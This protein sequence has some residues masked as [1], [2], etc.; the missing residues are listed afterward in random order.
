MEGEDIF[1]VVCVLGMFGATAYHI[2]MQIKSNWQERHREP[3]K[4]TP[5]EQSEEKAE[6]I[7]D[8]EYL[9]MLGDGALYSKIEL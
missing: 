5:A 8:E 6:H 7:S 3:P 9:K 1:A 4:P 2:A